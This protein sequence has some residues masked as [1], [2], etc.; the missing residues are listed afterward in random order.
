MAAFGGSPTISIVP[1]SSRR[2]RSLSQTLSPDFVLRLSSACLE[3]RYSTRRRGRRWPTQLVKCKRRYL[4]RIV[5]CSMLCDDFGAVQLPCFF[6]QGRQK[7]DHA[8]TRSSGD[9]C[10]A[11]AA[12]DRK[13]AP[14]LVTHES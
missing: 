8:C 10:V 4:H 3:R 1:G 13:L 12:S 9:S 7:T 11:A 6:E 2:D 5:R 14:P